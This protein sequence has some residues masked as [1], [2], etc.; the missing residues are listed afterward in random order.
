MQGARARRAEAEEA[1]VRGLS[2]LTL[3]LVRI[4]AIGLTGVVVSQL[5]GST[6]V[7]E[8]RSLL[9]TLLVLVLV[10]THGAVCEEQGRRRGRLQG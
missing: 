3:L 5:V 2:H 8:T 10:L 6:H 1:T 4:G 7:S 9:S